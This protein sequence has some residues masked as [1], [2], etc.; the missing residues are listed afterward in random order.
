[1]DTNPVGQHNSLGVGWRRIAN[2]NYPSLEHDTTEY[3]FLQY[4]HHHG[5]VYDN[6]RRGPWDY[7]VFD[8][9]MNFGDKARIGRLLIRGNWLTTPV[10]ESDPVKHMGAFVQHFEYTNSNAYEYGGQSIGAAVFSRWGSMGP[11]STGTRFDLM[12]TLM[13]AVNSNYSDLAEVADQERQREYDYGPGAGGRAEL[14]FS[15]RNQPLLSASYQLNFLYVTNGSIYHG[16]NPEVGNQ[17]GLDARHWLHGVEVRFDTPTVK[18]VSL[19]AQYSSFTRESHY[20]ITFP[21][22]PD[23]AAF[24]VT[25]LVKQTNPELKV[26]LTYFPSKE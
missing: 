23:L 17:I 3:G 4:F 1:M 9:Q 13:G 16:G 22:E 15:Y 18:S 14:S 10:G 26:F 24:S 19:G 7:F 5:S 6:D 11:I 2:G 8:G 21:E 12:G 25:Q 20:K